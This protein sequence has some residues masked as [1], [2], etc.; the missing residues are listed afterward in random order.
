MLNSADSYPKLRAG[1]GYYYYY[2]YLF[3]TKQCNNQ[4]KSCS[5]N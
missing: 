5:A 3:R 1:F 4:A 2:Y